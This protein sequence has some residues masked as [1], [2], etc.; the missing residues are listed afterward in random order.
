M[1]ALILLA[2]LSGCAPTLIEPAVGTQLRYHFCGS[3]AGDVHVYAHGVRCPDLS[4]IDVR[5]KRVEERWHVSLGGARV[6][7]TDAYLYCDET[8]AVGCQSGNDLTVCSA[9]AVW[10][11]FVEH[12]F[13]HL[14]IERLGNNQL[15]QF[16]LDHHAEESRAI[17]RGESL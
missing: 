17:L 5:A 9:L 14:A 2:M 3:T 11:G 16:D 4:A 1:R 13:T 8:E 12:E 10:P 15:Q 6:F 7:L